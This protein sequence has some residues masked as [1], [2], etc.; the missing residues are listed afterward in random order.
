[1][2]LQDWGGAFRQGT[3]ADVAAVMALIGQRVRWMGQRDLRQWDSSYLEL[4]DRQYF[5]Q[6]AWSGQLWVAE[7]S[8]GTS[9]EEAI[10]AAAVLTERD[11]LWDEDLSACYVHNLATSQR[12]PGLGRLFLAFLAQQ[13]IGRGKRA[14]RLDCASHSAGLNH[15]YRS[16]GFRGR[17]DVVVKDYRGC[18]RELL[19]NPRDRRRGYDLILMDADDTLLD[20]QANERAALTALFQDLG[21]ELTEEIRLLYRQLSRQLWEQNQEGLITRQQI[22]DSRFALLFQR[23]GREVDGPALERRYRQ[24]LNQGCHVI[25]G[26]LECCRRLIAQGKRLCIV[27]NGSS[28]IQR[29]KLADAGIAQVVPEVFVSEEVGSSKPDRSFFDEVFRR[30]GWE[31][32]ERA[33]ILGDSL[34]TDIRGAH[35]AGIDSCWFNPTGRAFRGCFRPSWEIR[36]L[37]EMEELA[38]S[39]VPEVP[40]LLMSW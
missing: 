25:P 29:K 5:L 39:V 27:T 2:N 31:D 14:L 19:L 10:V 24:Y 28:Q 4:Y 30:L 16:L 18:R 6:R 33:M 26:A 11:P 7:S 32:R 17:G 9:R 15:Y 13:A 35:Q 38:D 20:F 1:M 12:Y 8:Q 3:Q 36:R 23:L 34:S 22:L 40:P 37:E 21:L